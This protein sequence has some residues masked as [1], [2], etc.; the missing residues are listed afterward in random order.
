MRGNPFKLISAPYKPIAFFEGRPIMVTR[1]FARAMK[2]TRPSRRAIAD[3]RWKNGF[4]H[5]VPESS[6]CVTPLRIV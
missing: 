2:R 1:H 4:I 6:W 5:G 3:T